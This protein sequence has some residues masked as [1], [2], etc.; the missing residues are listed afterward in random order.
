MSSYQDQRLDNIEDQLTKLEKCTHAVAKIRKRT[1]SNGSSMYGKQCVRCGSLVGTWIPHSEIKNPESIEPMDCTL[2]NNY[3]KTC[4]EL[5]TALIER[6]REITKSDFD[7]SYRDYLLSDAWKEKRILVKRRCKSICEGCG[8]N[9]VQ[10]VHHLTYKNVE[11]EFLFELVG[12]CL[13]CHAAYHAGDKD[14]R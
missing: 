4:Q 3:F 14:D 2:Q 9:T 10:E 11:K 13:G 12:L 6:K 8:K 1:A 5:R 7:D